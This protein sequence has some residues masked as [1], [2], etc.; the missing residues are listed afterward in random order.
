MRAFDKT[1]YFLA[2]F[3]CTLLI[4]TPI[5][6]QPQN[7]RIERITMA[8]GLSQGSIFAILQD[9]KG[10]V[11][12]GTQDGLN[13]YDGYGFKSSGMTRKIPLRSAI[14]GF[15]SFTKIARRRF[16]WELIMA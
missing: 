2:A 14:I 5:S 6:S 10:F 11:W 8:Q 1:I 4:A 16:G 9:H 7:I 3:C 15:A 12:V 13:K